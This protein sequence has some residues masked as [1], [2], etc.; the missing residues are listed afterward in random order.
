MVTSVGD[1]EQRPPAPVSWEVRI[2][3]TN[4][5]VALYVLDAGPLCGR[6]ESHVTFALDDKATTT[7]KTSKHKGETGMTRT[8]IPSRKIALNRETL[9]QLTGDDLSAV[10]GGN[11]RNPQSVTCTTCCPQ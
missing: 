7:N 10:L 11:S 3:G 6:P 1:E 8:D 4:E 2:A 9:R 5:L